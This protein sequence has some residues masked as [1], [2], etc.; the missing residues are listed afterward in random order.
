[1]QFQFAVT[2]LFGKYFERGFLQMNINDHM[3]VSGYKDI[4]KSV[5]G[6]SRALLKLFFH[7]RQAGN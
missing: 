2:S 3:V 1:M 6:I 7:G 5:F 4:Q